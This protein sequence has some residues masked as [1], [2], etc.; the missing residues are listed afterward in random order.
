MTKF[1]VNGTGYKIKYGYNCFCGRNLMEN[2]QEL[3][4]LF[5]GSDIKNDSDVS[6]M[7]KVKDLFCVVR[8]LLYV[9]FKKYNPVN[10]VQEVGDILDDYLDEETDEER[11]LLPL[12][13]MLSEELTNEGFLSGLL[14]EMGN[15]MTEVQKIQKKQNRTKNS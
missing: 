10:S 9:G 6:G 13:V 11:G 2:V 8:D 4:K 14:K 12:F 5:S 7:G 15:Q 1:V 3:S